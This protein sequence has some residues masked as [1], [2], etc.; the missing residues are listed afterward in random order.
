MATGATVEE[1]LEQ[2]IE[3]TRAGAGG[4]PDAP[5]SLTGLDLADFKK[6]LKLT[7]DKM[8]EGLTSQKKLSMM[9][10]GTNQEYK[11]IS[12]SLQEL[13]TELE[14]LEETTR[15]RAAT[16][17]DT[18][19]KAELTSA[20]ASLVKDAALKNAGVAAHNF[21]LGIMG[22]A[23]TLANGALTF[24]K[25]LQSNASGVEVGTQALIDGAKASGEAAG[26]A[27]SAIT[28]MAGIASLFVKGPW[29]YVAAGVGLAG[30]AIGVLGKKAAELSEKGI[31]FIGDELKKTVKSYRD[32]TD[33]G[34]VLGGGMTEM[35]QIAYDA[36][37]SIDQLATVVKASKEDIALMGLGMGEATKR[38]TGVSKELRKSDLGSQLRNLGYGVEEQTGLI[39]AYSAR[40]RQAGDTRIQSDLE[41]AKGTAAY[42]RD[43]KVL[44]DITGKDAKAAMEKAAEQAMEQ[45]LMAEAMRKGGPEAMNKLRDQ[46][47]TMPETMKKGYMEFVSTGGTAIADAATNVAI[48]QNPKIMDQY[49]Q[50]YSTLGD[51]TKDASAALDETG[52]LNEQTAKYAVD[53]NANS[54]EIAMASR[55]TTDALTR[56][57][58][59][60]QN[61]LTKVAARQG[62]GTTKKSRE[63]V[64]KSAG[65]KAPLDKAVNDLEES[66]QSFKAA[67]G[68]ETTGAITNFA[69][70]LRKGAKSM[71]DALEELG[72]RKKSMTEQVGEVGGG[73]TGGVAGAAVGTAAGAIIGSIVPVIGTAIGA[74]AGGL[75]GGVA[76]GWLGKTAGGATGRAISG[77]TSNYDKDKPKMAAGGITQGQSIVGEAG[78]EAVVPLPNQKSIPVTVT[79]KDKSSSMAS[80]TPDANFED[81]KQIIKTVIP[82]VGAISKAVEVFT[83]Q[84]ISLNDADY[85][86]GGKF[87]EAASNNSGQGGMGMTAFG[88]NEWTGLNMGPLTTDL[89]AIKDIAAQ[90]GAFD[91][92]TQLI[93]DPAT[94]K[95][96]L[97]SGI[98]TNYD[99]GA[100]KVGTETAPGIGDTLGKMVKELTESGK[101]DTTT[102]LKEVTAE[103]RLALLKSHLA[104][105]DMGKI[106]DL[107]TKANALPEIPK[108]FQASFDEFMKSN[109]DDAAVARFSGEEL[110][111][112]VTDLQTGFA[113]S[114]K[115]IA[116]AARFSGED[117]IDKSDKSSVD[118]TQMIG[119]IAGT[120]PLVGMV[121]K[122]IDFFTKPAI[123][124]E[125]PKEMQA[126]FLDFVNSTKNDR[127]AT[128]TA[129]N[130]NPKIL[131]QYKQMAGTMPTNNMARPDFDTAGLDEA[132]SPKMTAIYKSMADSLEATKK[133]TDSTDNLNLGTGMGPGQDSKSNA[134]ADLIDSLKELPNL[135]KAMINSSDEQLQELRATKNIQQQ[136]A[137]NY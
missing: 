109:K 7:T 51:S 11:D 113:N 108:E 76:G 1:L 45:D 98:A 116:M 105:G 28:G 59:D 47:A 23:A 18:V 80:K 8:K 41:I 70:T 93:T 106:V 136:I 97:N 56:G 89:K 111:R 42:G 73:V 71:D 127:A 36:G 32:V 126:G 39:A 82:S 31:T 75:L 74:W 21:G 120:I 6:Q 24:A 3:V 87:W 100:V 102:A 103:F 40:Q 20:K 81:I 101:A 88:A 57:A 110:T 61:E 137:N 44:A 121:S 55:F 131:E 83:K 34:V 33:A 35:R 78:P 19:K 46:L 2:L 115:E 128:D 129:I 14:R 132:M 30:E 66:A 133:A 27:G 92:A 65:N 114:N 77:P 94:W 122:A 125:M 67:L 43:L 54:K 86:E 112:G 13:D 17:D 50:M 130:Q 38:L 117:G 90:L 119:K 124:P 85:K 9:L 25:G 79:L 96:I 60:I 37:L 91:K 118:I 4:S 5:A 49:K 107:L 63:E 48:S 68:K 29:K 134:N 16:H 69:D 58:T 12:Q 95:Q 62:E 10:Q 52:R 26:V 123:P 22:V 53:H 72:L 64:D 15:S 99:L 84:T 104:T 135:L